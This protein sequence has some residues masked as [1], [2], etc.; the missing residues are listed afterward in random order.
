M[1][2]TTTRP[3]GSFLELAEAPRPVAPLPDRLGWIRVRRG[4]STVILATEEIIGVERVSDPTS[5]YPACTTIRLRCGDR[6]FCGEASPEDVLLAMDEADGEG[7]GALPPPASA[8]PRDLLARVVQR[9]DALAGM[10]RPPSDEAEIPPTTLGLLRDQALHL[11]GSVTHPRDWLLLLRDA[12]QEAAVELGGAG[13]HRS[14][15]CF[16]AL[17]RQLERD[18]PRLPAQAP[19]P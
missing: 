11:A 19:R 9:R 8:A 7:P 1:A 12:A 13:K 4:N 3:I 16:A 14:A 15:G 18:V 2:D 6:V 17:A 10:L 5:G